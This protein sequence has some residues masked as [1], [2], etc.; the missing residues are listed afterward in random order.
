MRSQTPIQ[1]QRTTQTQQC[2]GRPHNPS[3]ARR[4]Q[5]PGQW[6]SPLRQMQQQT[7]Q[8]ERRKRQSTPLPKKRRRTR[9]TTRSR[10]ANT[11]HRH[12]VNLSTAI[13]TEERRGEKR[14]HNEG[15]QWCSGITCV[16]AELRAHYPE[17]HQQ[18]RRRRKRKRKRKRKK[19]EEEERERG[20]QTTRPH[21]HHTTA[22]PQPTTQC[23]VPDPI[24]TRGQH[25][26]ALPPFNRTTTQ[27][28]GGHHTQDGGHRHSTGRLAT[29]P[30]FT[31]HATHHPLC[32]PTIHD[33]PTL[34]HE[35]GRADRGYP[36]TQTPTDI[37][38]PPTHHTPGRKQ[39]TT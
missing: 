24:R 5:S 8:R 27:I 11:T 17:H 25:T 19:G 29:Q 23:K 14:E 31:H 34:H 35:R 33:G 32:R 22:I 2:R 16:L 12:M 20:R 38:S 3:L 36:T 28:E 21:T 37:H 10:H 26:P 9:Q 30:P 13:P 6:K 1:Q 18:E 4:K 39:C 7:R 15:T